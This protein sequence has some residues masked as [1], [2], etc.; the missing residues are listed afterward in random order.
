MSRGGRDAETK[1]WRTRELVDRLLP[2]LYTYSVERLAECHDITLELLQRPYVWNKFIKRS[3]EKT[4]SVSTNLS[5]DEDEDAEVDDERREEVEEEIHRQEMLETVGDLARILRMFED[6]KPFLLDLLHLICE[7]YPPNMI[8]SDGY[9]LVDVACSCNKTHSVSPLGFLI[10]DEVETTL[11]S[12]EQSV[13]RVHLSRFLEN[14]QWLP[15][16][17]RRAA[18][19]QEMVEEVNIG[20]IY[21]DTK[22]TA[23]FFSAL[24][25]NCRKMCFNMLEIEAEIGVDGWAAIRKVLEHQGRIFQAYEIVST[26]RA[27]VQGGRDDMRAIWESLGQRSS[28]FVNKGHHWTRLES[29]EMLEDELDSNCCVM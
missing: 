23:E 24:I 27:M 1:F 21:I 3:I 22:Q 12:T 7:K 28:W 18:C 14:W 20:T 16:I 13:E 6:S 9:V 29:L 10:L 2:F 17:M 26:K 8:S 25:E 15:E 19:Q 4:I 11:G 5:W